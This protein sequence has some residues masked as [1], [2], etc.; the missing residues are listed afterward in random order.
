L[1]DF[2]FEICVSGD[3]LSGDIDGV[4]YEGDG[5]VGALAR[6]TSQQ[7]AFLRPCFFVSFLATAQ[8]VTP[9]F[10]AMERPA[11]MVA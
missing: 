6:P 9:N 5:G 4:D 11:A 8:F 10:S 1:I 2:A 7:F 3:G